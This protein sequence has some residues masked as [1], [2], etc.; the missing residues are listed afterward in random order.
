MQVEDPRIGGLLTVSPPRFLQKPQNP[1]HLK[2]NT[3]PD[4]LAFR[5]SGAASRSAERIWEISFALEA[6][7]QSQSGQGSQ[8][9]R[10]L[11]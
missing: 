7:S 4:P 3:S 1:T 9:G 6:K 8:S 2:M 11:P 5:S 10:S